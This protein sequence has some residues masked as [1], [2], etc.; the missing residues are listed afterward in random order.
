MPTRIYTNKTKKNMLLTRIKKVLSKR[1]K[2]NKKYNTKL[3]KTLNSKNLKYLQKLK[4]KK[5]TLKS[6]KSLKS[7]KSL[8]TQN[9]LS[10]KSHSGGFNN[11]SIASVK[12][13]VFNIPA[14]GG[15]EGLTI[16]ESRSAIYR[17]NCVPDTYQ[18]MM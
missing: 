1:H 15:I 4:H 8:T 6:I 9:K 3:Q 18:A 11:C 13:P 10:R 7:L 16:P 2:Q 12:E 5:K 14:L 17:P